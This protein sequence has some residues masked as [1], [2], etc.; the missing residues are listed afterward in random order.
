MDPFKT[1]VW[2]NLIRAAL[3]KLIAA[4]P[5]FGFPV[6]GWFVKFIAVKL[7]DLLYGTMKEWIDFKKIAI[8]NLN[9]EHEYDRA[10]MKLRL[11]RAQRGPDSPEYIAA[12]KEEEDAF[13]NLVKFAVARR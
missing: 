10:A 7:T 1:L 2:D 8:T 6:I 4:F 5:V 11:M 12:V 13:S 9:L 3:G